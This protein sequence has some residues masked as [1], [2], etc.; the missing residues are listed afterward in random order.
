M[1]TNVSSTLYIKL[2]NNLLIVFLGFYFLRK[3]Y[4]LKIIVV[5]DNLFYLIYEKKIN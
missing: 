4:S 1:G 3:L 5:V 2:N